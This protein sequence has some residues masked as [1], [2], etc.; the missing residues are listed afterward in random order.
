MRS[1][2]LIRESLQQNLSGLHVSRQRQ[3]DMIDKIVG[4]KRMK[5][6]MPFSIVLAAILA[7][8]SITALA[9]GTNLFS[10]FSNRDIRYGEVAEQA[11]HIA[12]SPAQMESEALGK[13]SA[14]IDSA[15]YD[16]QSLSVGCIIDNAVRIEA[17]TP[18]ESELANAQIFDLHYVDLPGWSSSPAIQ[19][20]S[21]SWT[22]FARP[23]KR[24]SLTGMRSIRYIPA[25]KPWPTI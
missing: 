4:G 21:K 1:K 5:R 9:A 10:Y 2:D 3:T 13:V 23:L 17:Y 18:S 7:L 24:A 6:K 8:M 15:Y 16:G 19:R 20:S 12:A 14:R 22:R 11:A 25:V